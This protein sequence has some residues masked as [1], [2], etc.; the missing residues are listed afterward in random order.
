MHVG[1]NV[2][3]LSIHLFPVGPRNICGDHEMVE[4][5]IQCA[6]SRAR[7]RITAYFRRANFG[8]F[9]DLLGGIPWVRALAGRGV[10]K[11]WLL[12][13]HHFLHSQDWCIPMNKKSSKGGRR[14]A[15][16]SKELLAKLK[17]K[18]KVWGMWKEGQATWE[19]Y[20][21]VVRACRE[22]MRKAKVHL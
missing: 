17:W 7:S 19:E 11:S 10:H 5:R 18:R 12:F 1:T 4:F 6:E 3:G 2:L 15:W 21:S 20:R 8:L 13:K 14:P 9:Q 22:A 16:I